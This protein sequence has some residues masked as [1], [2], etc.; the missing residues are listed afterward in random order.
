MKKETLRVAMARKE[1]SDKMHTYYLL[2]K[3]LIDY[4]TDHLIDTGA[5]I[6]F[7]K[8]LNDENL[9]SA[10]NIKDGDEEALVKLY[11]EAGDMYKE[12]IEAIEKFVENYMMPEKDNK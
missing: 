1:Y 3:H 10:N 8:C 12:R 2:M 4:A 6:G 5:D 7:E 11:R 9:Y